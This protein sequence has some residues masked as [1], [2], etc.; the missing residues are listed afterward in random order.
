MC[1]K[2]EHSSLSS[3]W[4]LDLFS[5]WP[6]ITENREMK[7]YDNKQ[8]GNMSTNFRKNLW[9]CF[10]YFVFLYSL[11]LCYLT[12]LTPVLV[13]QCSGVHLNIHKNF[14]HFH[15]SPTHPNLGSNVFFLSGESFMATKQDG[16][17][18]RLF[19][20]RGEICM[21]LTLWLTAGQSDRNMSLHVFMASLLSW[22]S[23]FDD[24]KCAEMCAAENHICCICSM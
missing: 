22:A 14:C 1:A 12:F 13:L 16:L 18:F 4:W 11:Y 6:Q 3:S 17:R 10:F 15:K 23:G 2:G 21:W 7:I 24:M 20:I 19:V 5:F 8:K 9:K